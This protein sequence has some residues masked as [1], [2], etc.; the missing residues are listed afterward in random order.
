[1][2]ARLENV[3]HC[4]GGVWEVAIEPHRLM[5]FG[6]PLDQRGSV[7][8]LLIES[9]VYDNVGNS[10]EFPL[11][12]AVVMNLG[13][14]S[15]TVLID[16]AKG[17]AD[18]AANSSPTSKPTSAGDKRF[19]EKLGS[20]LKDK[21]T[22][23]E[24]ILKAIRRQ[25][26]GELTFKEK[27][28][29]F[30]ESPDNFWVVRIQPRVR[31]LRIVVYGLPEDHKPYKRISLKKDMSSYS[32]FIVDNMDQVEEAVDAILSAKKMKDLR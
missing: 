19:L 10:L 14:T 24:E 3:T 28:G 4:S 8:I 27:S 20:Q 12:S 26:A 5:H 31:N 6:S 15:T 16:A 32:S 29:K 11:D 23:G 1:M 7:S 13:C 21:R 18:N 17:Q 22:I 30:V 9:P 25:S 2:Y